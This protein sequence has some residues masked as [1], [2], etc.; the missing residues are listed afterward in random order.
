M[1]TIADKIAEAIGK[2]HIGFMKKKVL[3]SLEEIEA[4]TDPNEK[5]VAGVGAVSELNNKL[6]FPDG[7]GFYL[8]SQDGE[9][10]FNTDP[11]RGADTFCPF[12]KSALLSGSVYLYGKDSVRSFTINFS[13]C[14][15]LTYNGGGAIVTLDGVTASSAVTDMVITDK[16]HVLTFTV[17]RGVD[18][19]ISYAISN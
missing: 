15:T 19:H 2:Y 3:K 7:S 8:D 10:G 12:K 6:M 16:S 18:A 14:S 4:N 17:N 13:G 9:R 1:T 11:A 5:Y